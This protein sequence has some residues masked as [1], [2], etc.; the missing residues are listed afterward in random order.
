MSPAEAE[1]SMNFS[2]CHSV[3]LLSDMSNTPY[4]ID[5]TK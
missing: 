4:L 1:N 5:D 2:T 3:F